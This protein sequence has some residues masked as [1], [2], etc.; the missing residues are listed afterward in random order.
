[1][2]NPYEEYAFFEASNS[3][4]FFP[5]VQGLTY[6]SCPEKYVVVS[7]VQTWQALRFLMY[8][9]QLP[10]NLIPLYLVT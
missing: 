7:V 1:M 6:K 3:R 10:I 9:Y 4:L 2:G 8:Q 5:S